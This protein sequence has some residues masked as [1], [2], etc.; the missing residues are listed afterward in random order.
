MFDYEKYGFIEDTDKTE[1]AR[2][3]KEE[4]SLRSVY[5]DAYLDNPYMLILRSAEDSLIADMVNERVVVKRRGKGG[6]NIMN[7]PIDKVDNVYLKFTEDCKCRMFF[8]VRNI[9]Y[10]VMADVC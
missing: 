4:I 3:L 10:S 6:A 7:V 5:I 9:C 2:I 1:I 8:T